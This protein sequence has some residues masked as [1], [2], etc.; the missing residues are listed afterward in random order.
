MKSVLAAGLFSGLAAAHSAAWSVTV[1]GAK[2]VPASLSSGRSDNVRYPA[3]DV[4]SDNVLGAKR[5]EWKFDN[6]YNFPWHAITDVESQGFAC[7]KTAP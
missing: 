6:A 5:I 4:R 3:R 7:K 2:F 1:D